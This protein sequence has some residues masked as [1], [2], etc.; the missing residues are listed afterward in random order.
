MLHTQQYLCGGKTHQHLLDELGIRTARHE[1]LPLVILNYDQIDSPRSHPVVRECR[2][3][4]LHAQTHDLVAR[5]FPRF[6]N[7]GELAEEMKRFDFSAFTAHTKED[8]SLVLLFFF[9]GRWRLTTRGSFARD[10]MR[11]QEVTWHE[12]VCRALGVGDLSQ[13]AGRLDESLTYVCEFCSPWNTVVRR[14]AEPRLYLLSA[15]RG[16]QELDPEA[17]DSLVQPPFVRPFRHAFTSVEQIRGFLRE[18]AVN[19]P[20]FEG[21]VIRDR[22]GSR[23]KIKSPTY[24][25]LHQMGTSGE[26]AFEPKHL[27]PFILAGEGD[28]LLAYYPQARESYLACKAKVESAYEW[29]EKTWEE[30]RRIADQK[31]FAQAIQ[32]RTPFTAILFQL[33]KLHG[34]AQTREHLRNAW[35]QADEMILKVLFRR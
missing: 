12:A 31:A 22:H 27:L 29:L 7:W 11:G 1:T 5:A 19:D 14:Y 8:G 20:T 6:F 3:L 23:W 16:V 13:L 35:R 32:G 21:V 9:A 28:E 24:L 33:R 10:V 34:A 2:G 18:Q 25:G 15:F 4:V 30:H 17:V 26:D